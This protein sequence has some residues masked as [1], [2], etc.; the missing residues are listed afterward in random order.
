MDVHVLDINPNNILLS[1]TEL[2][3]LISQLRAET[4]TSLRPSE[5][6][7]GN[8][9]DGFVSSNPAPVFRLSNMD[10]WDKSPFE[11]S[12]FSFSYVTNN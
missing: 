11:P 2:K 8:L 1:P 7:I 6:S 4:Q 5:L 10:N 12:Y 9:F 3:S